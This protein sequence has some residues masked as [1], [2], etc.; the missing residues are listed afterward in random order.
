M[1][2]LS[3]SAAGEVCLI[4]RGEAEN[5]I[6]ATLR[7]WP[8]WLRVDVERDP[9][10]SAR[11]L[12][13]TLIADELHEPI[14]RDILKRSFGMTFPDAGGEVDLPPEPP[15]RPRRRSWYR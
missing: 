14:V 11:C 13:V 3:K 6:L 1:T 2:T 9:K 4:L 8:Y 7:H 15:A 10:D 12:S 5:R